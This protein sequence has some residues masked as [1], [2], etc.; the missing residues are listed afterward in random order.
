[1]G[2][3]RYDTTRH[4][5]IRYDTIQYNTIQ[6]ISVITWDSVAPKYPSRRLKYKMHDRLIP[7]QVYNLTNILGPAL[8]RPRPKFEFPYFFFSFGIYRIAAKG[9]NQLEV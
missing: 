2:T 6:C 8:A 3:I 5:T 9:Q 1:M 7:L 4:D